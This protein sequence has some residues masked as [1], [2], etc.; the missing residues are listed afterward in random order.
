VLKDITG[1]VEKQ[2][3]VSLEPSFDRVKKYILD[4]RD[5]LK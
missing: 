3:R 4:S 1:W 2:I 5:L